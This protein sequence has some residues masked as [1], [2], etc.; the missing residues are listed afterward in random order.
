MKSPQIANGYTP[1][2]NE[3]LEALVL[4]KLTQ[5]EYKVVMAVIRRTYGYHKK[6]D[7]IGNSRIALMTG[8]ERNHVGKV[9]RQLIKKQ[10]LLCNCEG[11]KN[12]LGLNKNY[13]E[14]G[15]VKSGDVDTPVDDQSGDMDTLVQNLSGDL[16]TL[17]V[18]ICAPQF[19]DKSGDVDTPP[20]N[21]VK[22]SIKKELPPHGNSNKNGSDEIEFCG[23]GE[24]GIGLE[25][26]KSSNSIGSLIYP[27]SMS[28]AEQQYANEIVKSCG[29][30]A[31]EVVDVLAAALKNG[32]V[33]TS[34][35]NLLSG[36]VRRFNSN[37]FDPAPGYIIKINR[38]K[39]Q[40]AAQSI[41]INKPRDKEKNKA[42]MEQFRTETRLR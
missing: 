42:R 14:W 28:L 5:A 11:Y 36:L 35:L 4:Y 18:G 13:A 40:L 10:I 21:K 33:Q 12:S 6:M 20:I 29:Q 32:K 22:E 9:V 23:G 30:N 31:Q 16:H 8:L 2:A 17:V 26:N 27:K 38:E 1:I 39:I 15:Q 24:L 37:N 25:K 3:L 19:D 41:V 34:S 7:A